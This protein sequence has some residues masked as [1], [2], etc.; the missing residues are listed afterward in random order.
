MSDGINTHSGQY[1]VPFPRLQ[2]SD[3]LNVIE[4]GVP[5]ARTRRQQ[6]IH[7]LLN[8]SWFVAGYL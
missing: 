8:I 1:L 7:C 3:L 4:S 6:E 2:H 5:E